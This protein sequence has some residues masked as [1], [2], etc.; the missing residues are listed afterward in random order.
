[1]HVD[2]WRRPG[3]LVLLS[4]VLDLPDELPLLS[5]DRDH[6]RA[7]AGALGDLGGEV[8]ELGVAV[9]VLVAFDD[10]GV[11]LQAEP[12]ARAASVR[13]CGGTPHGPSRST[14]RAGL[15]VDFVV[16]TCNDLGSPRVPG[17]TSAF[18]CTASCGSVSA[19]AL[20]PPPG[21]RTLAAGSPGN[22]RTLRGHRVRVYTGRGGHRL[23]DL[24]QHLPYSVGVSRLPGLIRMEGNLQRL[25][26]VHQEPIQPWILQRLAVTQSVS[27]ETGVDGGRY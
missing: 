17:S 19:S 25:L 20:R 14:P 22:S 8:T 15:R 5:I 18:S 9:S 21:A 1:V 4:A 23:D 12:P 10:L 2:P 3:G 24:L 26:A 6:R 7:G 27:V 13:S 11:A 16:H